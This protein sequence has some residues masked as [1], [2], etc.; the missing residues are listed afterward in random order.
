M[1]CA[2]D[3]IRGGQ[4]SGEEGGRS[5]PFPAK[6]TAGSLWYW[7]CVQMIAAS[8]SASS[9]CAAKSS[10]HSEKAFSGSM[11]CSAAM[12]S[13]RIGLG[14]QTAMMLMSSGFSTA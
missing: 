2:G 11:L 12:R 14:S 10:S 7:S 3:G 9:G 13:L 1:I 6:A 5:Q 8:A 4:S